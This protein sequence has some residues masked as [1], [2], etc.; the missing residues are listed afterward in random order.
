MA[1]LDVSLPTPRKRLLLITIIA[2]L[3]FS[4]GYIM[5]LNHEEHVMEN[6]YQKLRNTNVTLY[7]SK[8]M[9]TRGFRSFLKEYLAVRD[10]SHPVAE[11]PVF[12][13]GRWALF[14]EAKRVS[15][16]FI[17]SNCFSGVMIEDGRL[18][19][20]GNDVDSH[21]AR[22]TMNG[23]TATAHLQGARDVNI[24]VVGYGNYLHHIVVRTP[25]SDHPR[26]G[27]MCH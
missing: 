21:A 25:G 19:F 15:D 22:Y 14:D 12:L 16:D 9:Q 5:L 7:L 10:Y 26:Y 24:D 6:Y 18:K 11:A 2:V 1:T 8:I 20:F 3:A 4:V 27:Y 23:S 13:V 17:P